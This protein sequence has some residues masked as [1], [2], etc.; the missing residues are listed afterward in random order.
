MDYAEENCSS[1]EFHSPF[2]HYVFNGKCLITGNLF[3][4][5]VKAEE[6]NQY[7]QSKDIKAL[8]SNTPEERELLM[9]GISLEGWNLMYPFKKMATIAGLESKR[10]VIGE[11]S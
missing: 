6:L 7:R 8:E 5:S 9:S 11:N 10:P 4:I 1:K 3:S 2:H